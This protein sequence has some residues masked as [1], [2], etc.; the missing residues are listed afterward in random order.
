MSGALL[1][2]G[3]EMILDTVTAVLGILLIIRS[4][5]NRYKRIWG[6]LVLTLGIRL[7]SDN[8]EIIANY[9]STP[10]LE[11]IA[12]AW[13]SLEWCLLSQTLTLTVAGS[14]RPGYLTV[15]RLLTL[16]LPLIVATTVV[17]CYDWFG[18]GTA[19][20]HSAGD[21]L[22]RIDNTDV[23]IRLGVF[24]LSVINPVIYM[25]FPLIWHKVP[26]RKPTKGAYIYILSATM[27]LLVYIAYTLNLTSWIFFVYGYAVTGVIGLLTVLFLRYENPFSLPP[28]S[29]ADSAKAMDESDD[30]VSPVTYLLYQRMTEHLQTTIP[31]ADPDYGPE[32]LIQ[33]LNTNRSQLTQAIKF[34]GYTNFR[35]YINHLRLK[36]FKQLA[37]EMPGASVKEL[38]YRSGF[39]SRSSFYRYFSEQESMS[40]KQYLEILYNKSDCVM[41]DDEPDDDK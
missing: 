16:S 2:L 21:L 3:C 25:V 36:H 4:K 24:L 23:Q 11:T 35:E 6:I 19:T 13:L 34:G 9:G 26:L 7:L 1:S 33:E 38:M 40:P 28:V 27:L 31:F 37:T 10:H 22:R 12:S 5:D 15:N 32:G 17:A 30:P 41:L 20:L 14:F 18:N 39:N 8:Y 29:K